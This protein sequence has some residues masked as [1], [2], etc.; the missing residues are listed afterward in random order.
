MNRSLAVCGSAICLIVA[1]WAGCSHEPTTADLMRE[2]AAEAQTQ[3]DL[4]NEL[5]KEW[6]K[7]QKI[8]AAGEKRVNRG[9]R[10]VK[11]AQRALE[12]IQRNLKK[13]QEE[14]ERGRREIAKGR[15]MIENSERRFRE[16]FPSRDLTNEE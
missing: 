1:V 9:E 4:K 7:G 10:R 5:A 8:A 13:G 2:H 14:I 6:E 16:T 11:S 3:V 12:K 15:E